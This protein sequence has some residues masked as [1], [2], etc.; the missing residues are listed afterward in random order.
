MI[1]QHKDSDIYTTKILVCWFTQYHGQ[2]LKTPKVFTACE[3]DKTS[4]EAFTWYK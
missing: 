2:R 1:C 3:I 4:Q